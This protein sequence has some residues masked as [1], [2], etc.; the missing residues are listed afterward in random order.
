MIQLDH[1]N[2]SQRSERMSR[3]RRKDTAPEL[4]VRPSSMLWGI[5]SASATAGSGDSLVL[6]GSAR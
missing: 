6:P 4:Q 1:L 3:I 2:P 5:D